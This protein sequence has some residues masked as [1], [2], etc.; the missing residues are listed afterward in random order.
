MLPILEEN[1]F[2]CHSSSARRVRAELRL[3][4]LGGLLA[5]GTSGPA[6]APGDPD[7]SLLVEAVRYA[8]DDYA[9]PPDG[10][11]ETH[12]I[13]A[14]ERW[15]ELGAPWPGEELSLIHISEPTRPY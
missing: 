10:P 7:R 5:G 12:E 3:D 8:D 1:C 9:M 11:L 15:V 2:N 6:L 14:I 13:E 4:T